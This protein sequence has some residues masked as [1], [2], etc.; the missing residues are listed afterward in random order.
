VRPALVNGALGTV[1]FLDGR[2]FSVRGFTIR[3][4]RIVAMDILADRDRLA[5]LDL[6]EF[7]VEHR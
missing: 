3:E 1:A 7:G 6:T 4:R 5:K 2:P